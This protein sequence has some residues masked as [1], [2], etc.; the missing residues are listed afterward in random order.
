MI[1]ESL[2][3]TFRRSKAVV[4]PQNNNISDTVNA[5]KEEENNHQW[6]RPIE[7]VLSLISNSVGLGNVW[8]FPYLAAQSGGGA[9][10]IPYFTLYFLIGA[11]LYY[12]EL[13]LGQ[14]TSRGPASAFVLAKGWQGVGFAMIINSI[15]GTLYYNV[16]IAWALFYFV[17]SFRKRLLWADCGHW[18][19]SN[20]CFVPGSPGNTL[21][22]N[23][24]ALNCTLFNCTGGNC[25][26]ALS[27]NFSDSGCQE[28]NTTSVKQVTVTEEFFYRLLLNK[29]SSFDDFG[30]PGTYMSVLLLASWLLIC[31]CI[32]RGVQSSG[33]VAY[34]TAIFPYIVLLV[35][36]I[37]TATLDGAREGIIFYIVPRWELIGSFKIWQAAAS[38]VF[39]SLSIS[40]G[41][42]IAYSAA[43]DFHNKFFQQMCIVVSCDC[44]TGVFAG[45]AVF[46]TIGFLAKSLNEPVEV[47]ATASG[48]GLAFIT[49]PA[50]LAKMPASPFFSIIFF[51]MLLALGLG[52]QF[53][54]TDVPVTALMEFFPSY[55]KR[56]SV[57]VVITCSVF[58]LA[59]LPFACPGGIYLFELFQEYTANISLVF[60]GFFEV[61]SI[62][63]IYGF[64]RFMNDVEMMLG[65]RAAQY[66]LFVTWCIT[67]PILTLVITATNLLNTAPLKLDAS[68]GFPPYEFPQWSTTLGWFIF[69]ICIIPIPLVFLIS[70]IQEYRRMA[71][72]KTGYGPSKPLFLAALES[73][74]L[75]AESWGP[76]KRI[77]QIDA[78]AHLATRTTQKNFISQQQLPEYTPRV[79]ETTSIDT[80][81]P[82]PTF[83]PDSTLND[84]DNELSNQQF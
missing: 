30:V 11:P 9:F 73:N 31:V 72:E 47:Y 79:E 36:I 70:Y 10:L 55:A 62:A 67:A 14:F 42:L 34:F 44:F 22:A 37:F 18:W 6:D 8:R 16:I 82:N 77:H 33:K 80:G 52:S 75:P 49:Y 32:I 40:F 13:A 12:L 4:R 45:F 17:L 29:S 53:A 66:Y 1:E 28:N 20:G 7:F 24:T 35:L 54:S 2:V 19:N 21:G 41:S 60:I 76:R 84:D 71:K 25:T 3:W 43:N 63:Y 5:D 61:V 46:A 51:L 15:L 59:S 23:I 26:T 68:G 74:N 48:P 78:Y 39:F 56:R 50:A 65:K 83:N 27:S 69:V 64:N 38:Q 58:Y 57:L 81:I